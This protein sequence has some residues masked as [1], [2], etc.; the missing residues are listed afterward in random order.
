MIER[1]FIFIKWGFINILDS[2]SRILYSFGVWFPD[3]DFLQAFSD[4][5]GDDQ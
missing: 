5:R 2:F 1:K 3:Y 4:F